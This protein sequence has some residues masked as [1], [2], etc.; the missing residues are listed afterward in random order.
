MLIIGITG[1][2]GA[3]KGTIVDYLTKEKGFTHF[4]VRAYLITEIEKQGMPVNRDSMMLV[5][6][7][8]RTKHSPSFIIDELYQRALASQKHCIIESI[9]TPGEVESLNEKG[10]FY[11]FAVDADPKL[12]YERIFTRNSETDRIDYE[13]FL[14]NE[15]REMDANDPNKQ[16]LRKCIEMADFVFN[17][18]GSIKTLQQQVETTLELILKQ[19]V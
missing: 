18:N 4:S 13:T 7:G 3:G 10:N 9:R 12:R 2:L 8:L 14:E 1:T 11:L 16:N 5:A 6:N 15:Q 19:T 17:N